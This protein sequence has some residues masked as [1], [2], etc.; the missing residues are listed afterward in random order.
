[1]SDKSGNK[2][3]ESETPEQQLSKMTDA[4]REQAAEK[5]LTIID[6]SWAL[7]KKTPKELVDLV[8]GELAAMDVSSVQELL[9]EELCTRVHPNWYNEDPTSEKANS[10]TC[11]SPSPALHATGC[12]ESEGEDRGS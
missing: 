10:C 9:I 6:A 12:P 1:M 8:L 2:P 4:Q 11:G 3:P 7:E 5:L